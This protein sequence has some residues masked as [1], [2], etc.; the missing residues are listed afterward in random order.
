MLSIV[1]DENM[2]SRS[3]SGSLLLNSPWWPCCN[4]LFLS[5][6]Q[7][8]EVYIYTVTVKNEISCPTVQYTINSAKITQPYDSR[9]R[10]LKNM[11]RTESYTILK[12]NEEKSTTNVTSQLHHFRPIIL[13]HWQQFR[14][15]PPTSNSLKQTHRIRDSN[16]LG[17]AVTWK[18]SVSVLLRSIY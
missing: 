6:R 1:K 14:S 15:T 7:S 2:L 3:S 11:S 18:N 17:G 12:Q 5:S 16:P 13:K 10:N 8:P 9:P 4:L